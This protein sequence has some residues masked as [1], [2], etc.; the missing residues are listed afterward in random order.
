MRLQTLI[1]CAAAA[2]FTFPLAA[3]GEETL[4]QKADKL[5]TTAT[6][7]YHAG[8]LA[9][10]VQLLDQFVKLYPTNERV[11]GS[12]M[13]LF[14]SKKRLNDPAGSEACLDEV[15]R[16]FYSSSLW[17]K[18]YL[19]KL[20]LAKGRNVEE[21]LKL[22]ADLEARKKRLPLG[23]GALASDRGDNWYHNQWTYYHIESAYRPE[24]AAGRDWVW[25][26]VTACRKPELAET[27]LTIIAS[28]LKAHKD[29]LPFGWQYA[30]VELLR[31]AG[32]AEEAD[33]QLQAYLDQWGD[34]PRALTLW[35]YRI[36]DARDRKDAAAV[37]KLQLAVIE[38]YGGYASV[39]GEYSAY[40][41]SLATAGRYEEFRRA[42]SL[43]SKLYS[44]HIG[45]DGGIFQLQLQLAQPAGADKKD[46]SRIQDALDMLA[47]VP[48]QD[49]PGTH[50]WALRT[51]IDLLN[52]MGRAEEGAAVAEE[53]FG[54]KYWSAGNLGTLDAWAKSFP[55]YAKLAAKARE[56]W[57]VQ[58]LDT[59][60]PEA[61][62]LA[63][64]QQHLKEQEVRHAVE[65]AEDLRAT[66]PK[67]PAAA[68]AYKTM[69]DYFRA[70]VLREERDKW[71]Q[72]LIDDFPYLPM[73]EQTLRDQIQVFQAERLHEK[74]RTTLDLLNERFPG[75]RIQERFEAQ[76]DALQGE[77]NKLAAQLAALAAE[78]KAEQEE[79]AKGKP[80]LPP[81]TKPKPPS[82]A[83]KALL[84]QI[85]VARQA[86]LDHVTGFYGSR[87]AK[88][89][90][91]ALDE[92]SKYQL[93]DDVNTSKSL[94]DFW[95]GYA[96]KLAECRSGIYCLCKA[97]EAYSRYD[98]ANG[99]GGDTEGVLAAIDGLQKQSMDGEVRWKMAFKDLDVRAASGKAAEAAAEF[100][101]RLKPKEKCRGLGSRINIPG[102]AAAL[103]TAKRGAE[104]KAFFDRVQTVAGTTSWDKNVLEFAQ[105]QVS[106]SL[107][108]DAAAGAH[109]FKIYERSPWAQTE[110]WAFSEGL[111]CMSRTPNS[112][113]GPTLEN[114]IKALGNAQDVV[115]GLLCQ[116]GGYYLSARNPAA[117]RVRD[118]L[119]KNYPAS[120]ALDE[121]RRR[122]AEAEQKARGK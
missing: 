69:A 76:R 46:F 91:A 11:P 30:H 81:P 42:A 120:G 54:E 64:L 88:G 82:A 18:A 14:D 115:P 110:W 19:E 87:A 60:C 12:Y 63:S 16:R 39:G 96:G 21:Y 10:A 3:G 90:G 114:Y 32:K 80:P 108:N 116:V 109:Y 122:I 55:A 72:R 17:W 25:D 75:G 52:R 99:W 112:Q 67:H 111:G 22:L 59:K 51:R 97:Y 117:L 27:A 40:V 106:L 31:S 7:A 8:Q 98:P 68:A 65:I 44:S 113:Y 34:D 41:A 70:K 57:G 28:T 71:S 84:A 85:K 73:T 4:A 2:V 78:E 1:L 56:K 45:W 53:L 50:Q 121:L 94:G 23:F 61:R 107:K 5:Y 77:V 36:Q 62:K 100:A 29:E 79:A 104:L 43:Y 101:K 20:A 83:Q 119:A 58:D 66:A 37:E 103:T 105:A 24:L 86:V 33:K 92:L 13:L 38:R 95:M 102:M 93:P 118:Q 15:I 35:M 48:G 26:L 47:R 49:N 89:D 74:E 6:S 9:Q